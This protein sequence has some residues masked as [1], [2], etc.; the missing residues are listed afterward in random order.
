LGYKTGFDLVVSNPPYVRQSEKRLM[1]DKVLHYEPS[2]ALFVDDQDPLLFYRA[3][4]AFCNSNLL[5][6]GH[7]WVEINESFG[8]ETAFLFKEGGLRQVEI[9]KDIHEKERFIHARK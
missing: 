2:Q 4:L 3:I 5:E 9:K 6:G 8:K 7:L 1:E